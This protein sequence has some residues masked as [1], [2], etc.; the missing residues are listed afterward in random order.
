MRVVVRGISSEDLHVERARA[1]LEAELGLNVF[2][3]R[4]AYRLVVEGGIVRHRVRIHDEAVVCDHRDVLRLCLSEHIRQ[5]LA[6]DSDDHQALGARGNLL[7]DLLDLLLRG[8]RELQIDGEA[9]LLQHLLDGLPVLLPTR[10]GIGKG[11]GDAL[12]RLPAAA[13][14]E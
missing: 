10:R 7:L 2:P 9:L 13:A 8:I 1:A 4:L 6:V 3:H 12:I 14:R 11:D 5:R